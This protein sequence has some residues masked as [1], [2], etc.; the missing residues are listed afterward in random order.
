MVSQSQEGP[1]VFISYS[2]RDKKFLNRLLLHLRP[3]ERRGLKVWD[4]NKIKS[5]NQW[6]EEIKQ[7]LES[8]KVVILLVSADFLGSDFIVDDE[9]PA[10]LHAAKNRGVV[11]LQLILSPC[12][13]DETTL[14]DFQ[15]V[16][17]PSEPLVGLKTKDRESYYVKLAERVRECLSM[18]EGI[19]PQQSISQHRLQDIA[20]YAIIGVSDEALFSILMRF[21][22]AP[23]TSETSDS[24]SLFEDLY[25]DDIDEMSGVF[26]AL[27]KAI[28][29]AEGLEKKN[30]IP[31]DESLIRA[32]K[33]EAVSRAYRFSREQRKNLGVQSATSIPGFKYCIL[34]VR[35]GYSDM[36]RVLRPKELLNRQATRQRNGLEV[37]FQD[38]AITLE[39][40]R[41]IQQAVEL[42]RGDSEEFEN[43]LTDAAFRLRFLGTN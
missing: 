32:L 36:I 41:V 40:P 4:D 31:H 19:S 17:P 16:N 10:A 13:L 7:A 22:E 11:I 34:G 2:H 8:A 5:G 28:S 6:K 24:S 27:T 38:I 29:I 14:M 30:G 43:I 20:G 25:F 18:A 26:G 23:P 42:A 35:R 12:L 37:C 1:D 3:L 39:I 33:Y 15:A 9:I 21:G